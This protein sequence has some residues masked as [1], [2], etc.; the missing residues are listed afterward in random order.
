MGGKV[1]VDGAVC[2]LRVLTFSCL[3]CSSRYCWGVDR[4]ITM[5]ETPSTGLSHVSAIDGGVPASFFLSSQDPCFAHFRASSALDF[6]SNNM[7][8]PKPRCR[9]LASPPSLFPLLH[10]SFWSHPFRAFD[11]IVLADVEHFSVS[12]AEDEANASRDGGC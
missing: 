5:V 1:G 11:S 12:L 9:F 6:R 4:R 10:R 7:T 3:Y 8:N 2:A